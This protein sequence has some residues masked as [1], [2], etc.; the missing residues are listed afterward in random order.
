MKTLDSFDFRN[1]TVI[2]RIDLNSS[3]DKKKKKILDNERFDGATATI[4][5]LVRKKAKT[6]LLAHQGRNGEEDFMP[7]RQHA[8]I[9]SKHIGKKVHFVDDVIGAKAK[10]AIKNL[11]PGDILLLNNVRFV[12]D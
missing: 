6:V 8:D 2:I 4:S 9:L 1:K 11:K 3:Y 10:T 7:L 12:K 5:E